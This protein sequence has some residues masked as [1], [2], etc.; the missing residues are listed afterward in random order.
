MNLFATIAIVLACIGLFGLS[1]YTVKQRVKE[2][3]IRKVLGAS[4]VNIVALLSGNFIRLVLIAILLSSPLAYFLMRNWL[5]DFAYRI[6]IE[7]WVFA[8]VGLLAI[9]IALLTTSLQSIKAAVMN[10][11]ES[12][13]SE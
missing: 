1:S 5:Q 4:T 2:I 6:D 9:A 10:P 3:G 13:K 7:W 12:L 11:V 8:L